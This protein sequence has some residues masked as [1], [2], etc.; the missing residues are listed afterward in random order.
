MPVRGAA[1][2]AANWDDGGKGPLSPPHAARA[3]SAAVK[4]IRALIGMCWRIYVRLQTLED[5]LATL[6]QVDV[7]PPKRYSIGSPRHCHHRIAAGRT[8]C[9]RGRLGGLHGG[10]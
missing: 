5:A 8:R 2:L 4:A 7:D 3:A 10:R 1:H 6:F 9:F